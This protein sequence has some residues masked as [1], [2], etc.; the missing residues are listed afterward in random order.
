MRKAIQLRIIASLLFGLCLCAKAKADTVGPYEAHFHHRVIATIAYEGH[1]TIHL[2]ADSIFVADTLY[3]SRVACPGTEPI[4]SYTVIVRDSTERPPM[5]MEM[6]NTSDFKVP[7]DKIVAHYKLYGNSHY[8][9]TFV[10]T[11]L[12]KIYLDKITVVLE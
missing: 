8:S 4:R 10:N 11:K 12:P 3:I 2:K 6:E 5:R 1:T 7:L 9:L